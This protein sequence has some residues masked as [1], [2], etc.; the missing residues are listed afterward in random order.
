VQPSLERQS[1]FA[2]ALL[3][4]ARPV[5]SGL[6]GPDREPS[7]K[8]FSVYRNNVVVGLIDALRAN[9]AAAS[10]IVGDEFFRAMARAYVARNPPVSPILLDYGADFPDFIAAFEPA[11]PLPYLADVAR[12]ER[13][14]VEAY[15][16]AEAE[17]LSASSLTRVPV[18]RISD[19]RMELHPTVRIVRSRYP[20]LTIW[21]MNIADGEPSSVEFDAGGEDTLVL[22]PAAEVEVRPMPRGGAEFV[23]AL[24]VGGS[25]GEAMRS[26]S[27]AAPGFDLATHLAALIGARAFAGCHLPR[28]ASST[29]TMAIA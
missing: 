26:A 18:E 28:E 15:H 14:W 12:I 3:D 6:I 20:A 17:P 1:A 4:P 23:T 8:R 25:L 27:I 22:R 11:A 9:F 7:A 21:R 2:A 24:A 10:R 19:L 29:S 5:P 16:A 13:A